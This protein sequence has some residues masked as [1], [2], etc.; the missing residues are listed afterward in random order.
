MKRPLQSLVN[1]LLIL[2]TLQTYAQAD[3][4][5]L[6]NLSEYN[7]IVLGELELEFSNVIDFR[8]SG[9]KIDGTYQI[10]TPIML[11]FN[12]NN[13]K[14]FK[15]QP[16]QFLGDKY[17]ETLV[18]STQYP[19][20]Y[21]EE[22]DNVK[23]KGHYNA[24]ENGEHYEV[25]ATAE[26]HHFLSI[27]F[28]HANF[29]D[30][31]KADDKNL[32]FR[33]SIQGRADE[34]QP[35]QNIAGYA[36]SGDLQLT[37]GFTLPVMVGCGTFYGLDFVNAVMVNNLVES[38]KKNQDLFKLEFEREYF[39]NLPHIEAMPLINYLL[40]PQGN[41]EVPFSGSFL[42]NSDNGYEKASY[43]GTFRLFGK[44]KRY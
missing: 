33:L 38:D 29:V 35:Q 30:K 24:W 11:A 17:D 20:E 19:F 23:V 25:K 7:Y 9:P 22:A 31:I 44:P 5:P 37:E 32:Q 40:K 4:Q 8:S 36:R 10:K 26:L 43:T 16:L 6:H 28:N 12:L 34:S 39:N 42:S 13:L 18:A 21:L 1:F 3:Y 14:F 27:D 41:Y 2:C 15:A